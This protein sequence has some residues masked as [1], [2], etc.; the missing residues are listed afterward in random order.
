MMRKQ[1]RPKIDKISTEKLS[2]YR[3][4]KGKKIRGWKDRKYAALLPTYPPVW[5]TTSKSLQDDVLIYDFMDDKRTCP[6]PYSLNPAI[7]GST[8]IPPLIY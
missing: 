8:D 7:S 4:D 6:Y 2:L 3:T 5:E 1:A